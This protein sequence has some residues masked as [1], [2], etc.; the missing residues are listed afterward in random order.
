MSLK[1]RAEQGE[2]T[3]EQIR[4][5]VERGGGY[6]PYCGHDQIEGD[7][8]DCETPELG[9]RVHCLNPD[10]E[11]SWFDVYRLRTIVEG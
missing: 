1:P 10:C 11:R 5:Y 4:E 2:L 7:S 6:C 3:A 9:Q 8:Y